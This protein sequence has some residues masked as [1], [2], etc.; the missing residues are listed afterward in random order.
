ML[1]PLIF[2]EPYREVMEGLIKN[3]TRLNKEM[4]MLFYADDKGNCIIG[5]ICIGD[6]CSVSMPIHHKERPIG[7]FHV[8]VGKGAISLLSPA[9]LGIDMKNGHI[10]SCIGSEK[11]GIKCYSILNSPE[12]HEFYNIHKK[13][14]A[15]IYSDMVYSLDNA[16][17][18][19]SKLYSLSPPYKHYDKD[20]EKILKFSEDTP[21][22]FNDFLKIYNTILVYMEHITCTDRTST[23]RFNNMSKE[24]RIDMSF[25]NDITLK[26]NDFYHT[27]VSKILIEH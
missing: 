20:I 7:A 3:A 1:K 25:Y 11:D 14:I 23:R 12:S 13:Y 26:L 19:L 22:S 21:V 9:D 8:H 4:G 5:D 27:N 16:T 24:L 17:K 6:Q 10:F 2:I 15:H 18:L